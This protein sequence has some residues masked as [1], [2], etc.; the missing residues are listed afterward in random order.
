MAVAVWSVTIPPTGIGLSFVAVHRSDTLD[1]GVSGRRVQR[2]LPANRVR[3]RA[4]RGWRHRG[5][6]EVGERPTFR[7]SLIGPI[8]WAC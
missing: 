2:R 3:R 6:D 4:C 5:N 7:Q 8:F 1:C